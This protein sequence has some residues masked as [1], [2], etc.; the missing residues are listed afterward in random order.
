MTR[1]TPFAVLACG[2]FI[3]PL[4][5]VPTPAKGADQPDPPD[6]VLWDTGAHSAQPLTADSLKL[7]AGWTAVPEDGVKY[8]VKGDLVVLNDRLILVLRGTGTAGEVYCRSSAGSTLRVGLAPRGTLETRPARLASVRILENNPGAVMLAAAYTAADGRACSLAYRLTAGQPLVELR[9]G[10]G[11]SHVLVQRETSFVVVPDFFG[12]DMVFPAETLTRRRLR[13]PAENFFLSLAGQGN[14]Q[15]MCVWQSAGQRAV[16]VRTPPEGPRAIADFEI[17]AV[18]DKSLWVAVLEGPGLWHSQSLSAADAKAETKLDWKPPFP[19]K[20]RADLL[21]SDGSARSWFFRSP[22]EPDEAS[23]SATNPQSPC[24]LEVNRAVLRLARDTTVVPPG[25][26]YP[27][28]MV[29]YSLDRSRATPL[30]TFC[31]IDVLRNTLGVGPCQYILQTEGL[32]SE[33]NPTP[34]NVMA[35]IEKQFKRKKE[36]RAAPEIG[37]R[38]DQMVEH[39]GHAQAR[40]EQYGRLAGDLQSLCEAVEPD[41]DTSATVEA[42]GRLAQKLN[43][44]VAASAGKPGPPDQAAKLAAQ[45]TALIGKPGA[46]AE[47]ERI[48]SEIRGIGALQD[49]T[50]SN[51]RMTAR[52]LKQS[53]LM[54]AEDEPALAA[55]VKS[56]VTRTEQLLRTP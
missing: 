24:C 56:V 2:L 55:L 34:D 44:T 8:R 39:V 49:R 28:S 17:D 11:T 7:K 48:G 15:V 46:A 54:A 10:E 52:W 32:A 14:V 12:D 16:A 45:V 1:T 35:W 27:A 31:P 19:A 38:L 30:T 53:A 43:Q 5:A 41:K 9:P 33:T 4:A 50:L 23:L 37:Q 21:G 3:A 51:C 36:K 29:V 40:I 26:Q 42:I 22:E 47:C 13:L 25:W 20:W 18:K 6:T